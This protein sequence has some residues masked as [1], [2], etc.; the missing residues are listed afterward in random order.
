[1]LDEYI[2]ILLK[3]PDLHQSKVWI[4]NLK[5]VNRYLFVKLRQIYQIFFYIFCIIITIV[6]II[7]TVFS[8]IHQDWCLDFED[9]GQGLREDIREENEGT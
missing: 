7:N 6:K 5:M 9:T 2:W 1:M 4:F 8:G 3:L